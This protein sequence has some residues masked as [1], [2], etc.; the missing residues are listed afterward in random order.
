MLAK[1]T[2]VR[3]LLEAVLNVALIDALARLQVVEL[4]VV[5]RVVRRVV[6]H[7]VELIS[8]RRH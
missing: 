7:E 1:R 2:V 6:I 5:L 8:T 4:V 3:K